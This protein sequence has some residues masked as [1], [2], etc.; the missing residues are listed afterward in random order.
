MAFSFLV[1]PFE[2]MMV[3]LAKLGKTDICTIKYFTCLPQE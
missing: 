2:E 1:W 3:L